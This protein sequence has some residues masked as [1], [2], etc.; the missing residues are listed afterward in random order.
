MDKPRYIYKYHKLNV[1]LFEL[2]TNKELY[3]ATRD[4]LNDPFDLSISLGKNSFQNFYLEKYP[5][6]NGDKH[7]LD[8][9][10]DLFVNYRLNDK[11][12]YN[13][14]LKDVVPNEY[15]ENRTTCFTEDKNNSLM[16]SHYTDNHNGVCIKF[17]LSKDEALKNS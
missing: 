7:H 5:S 4:E 6:F 2:F 11:S 17:D 10:Y 8:V 16:W 13:R 15:L 3:L 9:I 1:F 12:E 14:L